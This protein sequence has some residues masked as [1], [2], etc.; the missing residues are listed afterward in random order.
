MLLL[1]A[2]LLPA[3]WAGTALAPGRA[4]ERGF[5]SQRSVLEASTGAGIKITTNNAGNKVPM[6][7]PVFLIFLSDQLA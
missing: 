2:V 1:P 6:H 4:C 3:G 7:I 5:T